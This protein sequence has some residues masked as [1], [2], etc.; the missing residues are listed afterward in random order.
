MRVLLFISHILFT[1]NV[2]AHGDEASSQE[3]RVLKEVNLKKGK[4][5]VVARKAGH[6]IGRPFQVE[7]RLDCE[8]SGQDV[9]SLK[10]QDSYSVCDL[11]PES[12]KINQAQTAIALKTKDADIETYNDR[13]AQGETN[14]DALCAK[15]TKVLKFSLRN[16][17]AK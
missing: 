4:A 8:G 5:Y 11:D 6:L 7:V 3:V 2:Y 1:F 17:C 13:I 10:V 15:E 14:V 16:L 12:L 9:Q